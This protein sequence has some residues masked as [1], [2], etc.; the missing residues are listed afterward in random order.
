MTRGLRWVPAVMLA[1]V[2]ATPAAAQAKKPATPAV[3]EDTSMVDIDTAG[4][5]LIY[6]REV[7][8]YASG[9]RDPFQTLL[10]SSAV[11]PTL[12]DLTLVSILYD[13]H[14]GRSV[15]VV[16]EAP[17]D[18]IYRLQRGDTIGRLHVL[19]IREYEVVFQI[20]EFGFERQEVLS[21]HKQAEANP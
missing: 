15:A 5:K 16:H 17:G 1:L 14:Y 20:E 19:Q 18:K 2:G 13:P 8:H 7:F 12:Q 10:S 11:R 9:A 3:R 6:Q 21:L 4:G